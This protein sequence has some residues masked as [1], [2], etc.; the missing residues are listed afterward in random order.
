MEIVVYASTMQSI[1]TC[2]KN[3]WNL[4]NFSPLF[5]VKPSTFST[6]STQATPHQSTRR[7][8]THLVFYLDH[9]VCYDRIEAK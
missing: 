1:I 4:N 6:H 3:M 9:I 5:L 2:C 7:T 8:F